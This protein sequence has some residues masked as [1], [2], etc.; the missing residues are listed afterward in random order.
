MDHVTLNRRVIRY[1]SSLALA[2]KKCKRTVVTSWC[3]DETSIKI[4]EKWVYL[5]RAVNK[6]GDTIDFMLTGHCDEA[7]PTMLD[8]KNINMLLMLAGFLSFVEIGQ[9]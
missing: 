3:M 5:Y 8:L 4:K 1:S 7:A 2:A 6:F 9:V